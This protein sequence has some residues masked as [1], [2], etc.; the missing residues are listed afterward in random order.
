MRAV[1][2][3]SISFSLQ[4]FACKAI[5]RVS[6]SVTAFFWR[7]EF[8]SNF[9]KVSLY[10]H[11]HICRLKYWRHKNQRKRLSVFNLYIF[12]KATEN[13]SIWFSLI[14]WFLIAIL[15]IWFNSARFYCVIAFFSLDNDISEMHFHN[16]EIY[17]ICHK[18]FFCYF[19][20]NSVIWEGIQY[21]IF[22]CNYFIYCCQNFI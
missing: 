10:L 22:C 16:D 8:F 13:N 6:N 21:L 7:V 17:Y 5:I 9:I 18:N 14:F 3:F 1:W 15:E 20:I 19:Y 2:F 12:I 4:F 11:L